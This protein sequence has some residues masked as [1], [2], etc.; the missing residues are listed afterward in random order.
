MSKVLKKTK[1]ELLEVVDAYCTRRERSEEFLEIVKT[2]TSIVVSRHFL[3]YPK[4]YFEEFHHLGAIK[5]CD[6]ILYFKREGD[7]FSFLYGIIRNEIHNWLYKYH[8]KAEKNVDIEECNDDALSYESPG[9]ISEQTFT[10][11]LLPHL[12]NLTGGF[13]EYINLLYQMKHLHDFAGGHVFSDE[14]TILEFTNFAS[15]VTQN[16]VFLKLYAFY[17]TFGEQDD[18]GA[19]MFLTSYLKPRIPGPVVLKKIIEEF[20]YLKSIKD[21][22]EKGKGTKRIEELEARFIKLYNKDL[23]VMTS[24][25][26]DKKNVDY[27]LFFGSQQD[28]GSE[29]ETTEQLPAGDS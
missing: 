22:P 24:Y 20:L 4:S 28:H 10:T 1:E 27:S 13:M 11:E 23:S 2:V 8:D 19:I 29:R 18:F 15:F 26:F 6:G 16:D 25:I 7:L 17:I 14:N 3:N 5:A 12:Y 9:N 21:T